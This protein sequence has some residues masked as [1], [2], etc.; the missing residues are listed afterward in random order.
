MS[1]V[2]KLRRGEGPVWGRL[3]RAARAVLSFHIPVNGLTRPAARGLYRVHVG[4]REGFIWARRFFWNE[5][6]FRGQCES[7]GPGF[8][9]EELPYINGAGRIVIGENVRLSGKANIGFSPRTGFAPELVIGDGT[10]V[11]H[12]CQFHVGRSVRIGR[13]CLLASGVK[14]YDLDGHPLDAA[15][16]RA[17]EPTPPEAI[18]PVVIEDDVW[19]GAGV[20]I[21]K[22]VTVGAR[23]V[24]AAGSIVVKDVPPDVVVAGCPARVVKH[25]AADAPVREIA[26]PTLLEARG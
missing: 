20:L 16:R 24:V 22:G 5:P 18:A 13:D 4:V 26:G 17:G 2:T 12:G 1:W 15:R 23:T 19:V 7:V 25:L 11:G 14:V 8:R 10:F 6:L 3:K 21:L 9:M